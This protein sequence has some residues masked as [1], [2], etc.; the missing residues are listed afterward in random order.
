MRI[1]DVALVALL[2]SLALVGAFA[3]LTHIGAV[4]MLRRRPPDPADP[5]DNYGIAFE[6]VRFASRDGTA[7]AGWWIPAAMHPARGTVIMCHGQAG[8]MDGDTAQMVPLHQAGFHVLMFDF[9][10]HGRS[11]GDEMTMGMF[12]AD[13]LLGALDYLTVAHGIG[14]AGVLGFSMGAATALI[15]AAQTDRIA[16]IVADS[17]FTRFKNTMARWLRQYG[18]PYALGWQYVAWMLVAVTVRTR[19]RIDQIDPVLWVPHVRCPVLFI[20]GEADPFVSGAEMAELT[21]LC[22]GP[23]ARW[24]VPGAGH[25]EAFKH[26]PAEY[27]QRVTA[28]FAQHLGEGSAG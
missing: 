21:R 20:R 19:G 7:L 26:A 10:A 23:S 9:R 5:P 13:D 25:R 14:R 16:A 8:S 18:I 3:V 12:E 15:A 11:A 17:S 27:N 24:E 2:G 4:R 6:E 28:W 1:A 22:A